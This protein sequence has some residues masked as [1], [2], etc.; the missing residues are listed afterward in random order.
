M[1]EENRFKSFVTEP[2]CT[3]FSAAA[4][5]AV[6]SYAEP[7]G[8]N[9]LERKTWFGN[10]HYMLFGPL[11]FYVL[12]A[13]VGGPCGAEQPFLSKM[14]WLRSWKLLLEIGFH[15][16][17]LASCQFGRPYKKQFR[18]IVYGL[19]L[20]LGPRGDD[21]KVPGGARRHTNSGLLHQTFGCLCQR[22][23]DACGPHFSKEPL[24]R[25]RNLEVDEPKFDGLESVVANA[26]LLS[27][28]WR[29]TKVWSWKKKDRRHINV[30]EGDAA[31]T[32]LE[33]AAR[34]W[35]DHRINLFG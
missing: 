35:E 12:V 13:V 17:F 14:A 32:M 21:S 7:L 30:L 24:D 27:K 16:I 28:P 29:V 18:F 20:W 33:V 19:D 8:Y 6:K 34:R 5:P 22:P 2:P 11:S 9:R 3:S 15:E 26:L 25:L 31:V 4:H 10:L 1:L 23:G